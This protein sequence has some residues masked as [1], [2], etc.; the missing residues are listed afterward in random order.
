MR[1]LIVASFLAFKSVVRG[2][3]GVTLLT[4]T[5]LVLV[6]LNLL[7]VPSLVNGIVFSANDKYGRLGT[8]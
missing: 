8:R 2:N 6:N 1:S 3:A 7:F 4:I 5:M